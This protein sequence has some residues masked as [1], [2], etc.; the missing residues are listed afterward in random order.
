M[1]M[2]DSSLI[3]EPF[4][5]VDAAV[6]YVQSFAGKAEELKLLISDDLNDQFGMNM[7]IITDAI[8]AKGFEPN[9]FEQQHG[10][11]VYMYK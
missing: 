6:E 4:N 11:R 8:L 7:A 10:H 2:S 5:T 3:N 9:G 1:I